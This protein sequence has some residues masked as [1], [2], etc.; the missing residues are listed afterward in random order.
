[1]ISF[2]FF[3]LPGVGQLIAE[4]AIELNRLNAETR[5]LKGLV[6]RQVQNVSKIDDG[7]R[8]A[9]T[10]LEKKLDDVTSRQPDATTDTQQQQMAGTAKIGTANVSLIRDLV[11][12][13]SEQRRRADNVILR[14]ITEN[15]GE[16]LKRTVAH[17][18]PDLDTS[19][20]SDIL[21]AERIT[22]RR[23]TEQSR[24]V[25]ATLTSHG[26]AKLMR[27]KTRAKHHDVNVYV[28]HDL[29]RGEQERRRALVPQYKALRSKGIIC[30]LPKDTITQNG[31]SLTPSEVEGLLKDQ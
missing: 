4:H 13:A 25:R 3:F 17:L 20:A 22:P 27:N 28:S 10:E 30:H 26:K 19:A 11:E 14:G 5:K 24:L 1:M 21:S 16:D 29:T 12:E 18:V 9:I 7:A 15:T 6:E 8:S 2:F 23:Q 31:K